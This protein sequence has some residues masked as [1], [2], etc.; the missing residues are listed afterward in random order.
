MQKRRLT[1]QDKQ[2]GLQN[3]RPQMKLTCL[4]ALVIQSVSCIIN[5]G[6]ILY[7]GATRKALIKHYVTCKLTQSQS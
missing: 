7:A 3:F 2:L 6:I 5:H 1:A 4:E